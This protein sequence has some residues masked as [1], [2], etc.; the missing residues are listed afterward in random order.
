MLEDKIL[1]SKE[2]LGF[3]AKRVFLEAGDMDAYKPIRIKV[4]EGL[5][6]FLEEIQMRD[7]IDKQFK[8]PGS[9]TLNNLLIVRLEEIRPEGDDYECDLLVQFFAEKEDFKNLMELEED[10]KQQTKDLKTDLEKIEFL[11]TFLTKNIAYD[12]EHRSRSALAAAITHKGTCV[13]FA[14]LFLILGEAI[15]LKV[16]CINSKIMKHRWNYVI[17]GDE[18]YYIDTAFNA[19]NPI[20][21][22]LFFQTSPIHLEKAP[23]QGI[24][25]PHG[26]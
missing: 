24:A 19:S 23:D 14:Q 25:V 5:K 18:T 9:S 2:E 4:D 20:S 16:G 15:G 7:G 11:N 12:K 3:I 26:Q 22:K 10:I 6:T 1:R 17:V 21:P 13:A 8:I